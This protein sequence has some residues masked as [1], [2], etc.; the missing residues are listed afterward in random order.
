MVITLD[1]IN[2]YN[3]GAPL[4]QPPNAYSIVEA[5]ADP[6]GATDSSA[7]IINAVNKACSSGMVVWVPPG[8]FTV[9]QHIELNN[10]TVA[11]AGPWYSLLHGNRVGLF[12]FSAPT[13]SRH[14]QIHG[15]AV[16]GEVRIR[17]DGDPV[18]GI[19]G[20]FSDSVI[21]NVWIAH[22]K[23]GMWLDG[24]FDN[25]LI[26]GCVIR[27]TTADGINFHDGISN[28]VVEHTALRNLGDD[29]LAMWS[30]QKPDTNNT[31]RLNTVQVPVLAN[32]IAIYGGTDNSMQSNLVYDTVAQ[33]GGLHVGNRFSSVP[34]A[35]TTR[36]FNNGAYRAGCVDTNWNFG[37]GAMWFYALDS[38]INGG[39]V[40]ADND[41]IDSSQEAIHFIGSS[42]NNVTFT[43]INITSPT[44]FAFQ[45][46]CGGAAY[47]EDVVASNVGYFGQYN[48]GVPF[49]LTLG[50]GNAGWNTT[51]CG[52]PPSAEGL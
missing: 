25:L 27:D 33:G 24:P 39:I 43:R 30:D 23:C 44:T 35:G 29:G 21:S 37:V 36:V 5:G 51:H 38:A 45:F 17:N 8:N 12:G 48:C 20:A 1:L 47:V 31:F 40:A 41:L 50:P 9:T 16:V 22:T 14:V 3:V 28:S 13:G 4:P 2:L 49:Q 7:A 19:G 15:V 26:T 32:N 42:V 11:G 52:W 18:N 10:V 6:T 34:L 46:Q